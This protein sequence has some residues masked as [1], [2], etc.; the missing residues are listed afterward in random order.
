VCSSDLDL[1]T[2]DVVGEPSQVTDSILFN[3]PNG[4][5]SMSANRAGDIFYNSYNPEVE[6]KLTLR[7]L[8]GDLISNFGPELPMTFGLDMSPDSQLFAAEIMG[9][10]GSVQIWIGDLVRGSFARLSRFNGDCWG[11]AFSPDSRE[12]IYGVQTSSGWALYRHRLSGAANAEK[13]IEFENYQEYGAAGHWFAPNQVLSVTLMK[14]PAPLK[15]L[16]SI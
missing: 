12:V 8:Q 11:A 5:L 9:G 14:Q 2:A 4:R 13:I 3:E 10:E 7:D 6:L 1:L 16:S 15:S